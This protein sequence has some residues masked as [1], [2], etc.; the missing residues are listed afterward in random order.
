MVWNCWCIVSPDAQHCHNYNIY[1]SSMLISQTEPVNQWDTVLKGSRLQNNWEKW[2]PSIRY[3]RFISFFPPLS[4]GAKSFFVLKLC[5]IHLLDTDATSQIVHLSF[6][7]YDIPPFLNGGKFRALIYIYIYW[8]LREQKRHRAFQNLLEM[9][10][11]S[12]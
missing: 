4:N 11:F 5:P 3:G 7:S 10:Y 8:E 12:Q 9:V 6:L 2:D 1:S